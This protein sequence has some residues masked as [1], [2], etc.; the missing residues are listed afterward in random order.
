M[1]KIFNGQYLLLSGNQ[2]SQYLGKDSNDAIKYMNTYIRNNKH[3]EPY[4]VQVVARAELPP[5]IIT[6]LAHEVL[7]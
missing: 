2:V 7:T 1:S 5:P 6:T 3:S 4:L